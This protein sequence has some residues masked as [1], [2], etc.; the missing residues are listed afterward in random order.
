MTE[1]GSDLRWL[2][3]GRVEGLGCLG[4]TRLLEFFGDPTLAFDASRRTLEGIEGV[5]RLARSRILT[6][7]YKVLSNS[8][9]SLWE[10][11]GRGG[12]AI[13]AAG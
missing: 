4:F 12:L 9:T 6:F 10:L 11:W 1:Q 5:S 8:W 13:T 7:S 2:A 3:L